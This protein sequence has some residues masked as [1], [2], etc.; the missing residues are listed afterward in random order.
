MEA[1]NIFNFISEENNAK[2]FYCTNEN[3]KYK[4]SNILSNVEKVRKN[5]LIF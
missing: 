3:E 1:K 5:K 2:I 4:S